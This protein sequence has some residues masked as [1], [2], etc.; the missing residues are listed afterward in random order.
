M[1]SDFDLMKRS[2][3]RED[4]KTYKV[5][6]LHSGKLFKGEQEK[7]IYSEASRTATPEF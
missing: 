6:R 1:L 4:G 5:V 7:F 3:I 2:H